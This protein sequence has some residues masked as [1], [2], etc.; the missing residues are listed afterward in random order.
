[1][2]YLNYYYNYYI[3]STINIYNLCSMLFYF[4]PVWKSLHY[5]NLIQ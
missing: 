2:C 3:I 4:F 1:M 5:Y